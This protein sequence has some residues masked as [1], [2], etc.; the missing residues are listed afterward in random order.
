MANFGVCTKLR[1]ET[2]AV[3]SNVT[4]ISVAERSKLSCSQECIDLERV[5]DD[6]RPGTMLS[7]SLTRRPADEQAAAAYLGP[8][9]RIPASQVTLNGKLI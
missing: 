6:R 2:R 3:G 5:N 8:L 4:L 1:V 9:R 7:A